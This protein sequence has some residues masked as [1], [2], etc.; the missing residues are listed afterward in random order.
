ML[1]I[2][3]SVKCLR[4]GEHQSLMKSV[5]KDQFHQRH[6]TTLCTRE[7]ALTRKGRHIQ[8]SVTAESCSF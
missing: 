8:I 7:N 5:L 6:K 3:I 2:G 1:D 4:K